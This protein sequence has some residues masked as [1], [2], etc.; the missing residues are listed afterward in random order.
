MFFVTVKTTKK[1]LVTLAVAAL[2]VVVTASVLLLS[3]NPV[4]ASFKNGAKANFAAQTNEE[5][6]TCI[7][8]FGWVVENEPTEVMEVVIPQ[9]FDSVY[10]EYNAIQKRQGFDLEKYKGKRVKKWTYVVTNYPGEVKNV[11]V[12][13]LVLDNK[14]IGGDVSG[15]GEQKFMHG[16]EM[17]SKKTGTGQDGQDTETGTSQAEGGESKTADSSTAE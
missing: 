1:K 8:S 17:P 13:L 10:T 11:Y 15:T 6:I 5:R 9:E 16:L 3:D 2:A 12:S 7:T 4:T 14:V